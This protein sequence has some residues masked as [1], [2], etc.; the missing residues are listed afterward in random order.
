MSFW[1]ADAFQ[2]RGKAVLAPMV[3]IHDDDEHEAMV[4]ESSPPC[5]LTE[6]S[7]LWM[8]HVST[9]LLRQCCAVNRAWYETSSRETRA[10]IRLSCSDGFALRL[11]DHT[12]HRYLMASAGALLELNLK[13]LS[14]ISDHALAALSQQP[15]LHFVAVTHCTRLSLGIKQHLPRSVRRLHICGCRRMYSKL[16]ELDGYE[17][18]VHCCPVAV[19]FV[20]EAALAGYRVVEPASR[21]GIRSGPAHKCKHLLGMSGACECVQ[22]V[23]GVVTNGH[24]LWHACSFDWGGFGDHADMY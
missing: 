10:A 18:D 13:G 21:F 23:R 22:D 24:E 3:H 19:N 7:E 15:Q 12:I 9:H 8:P 20:D 4:N 11:A 2:I 14:Q 16:Q 5:L 1:G 17:L 6:L